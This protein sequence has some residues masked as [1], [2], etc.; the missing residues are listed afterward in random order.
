MYLG[1][2]L[3]AMEVTAY[4]T[5][6]NGATDSVIFLIPTSAGLKEKVSLM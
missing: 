4:L 3:E 1:E 2:A 6:A 5:D